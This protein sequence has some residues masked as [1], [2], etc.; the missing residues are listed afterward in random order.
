[1]EMHHLENQHIKIYTSNANFAINLLHSKQE[2][3]YAN[4]IDGASN[5][6]ELMQNHCRKACQDLLPLSFTRSHT[7]A[8]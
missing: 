3:D 1:M 7:A 2:I 6:F 5:G 8:M 4:V